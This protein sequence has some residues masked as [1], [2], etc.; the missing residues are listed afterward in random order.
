M[1]DLLDLQDLLVWKEHQDLKVLMEK[2]AYLV[3]LDSLEEMEQLD[4]LEYLVQWELLENP[5]Q[6][7]DHLDHLDH[8]VTWEDLE[9]EDLRV[10][11]ESREHLV[12]MVFLALL[13]LLVCLAQWDQTDLLDHLDIQDLM[14]YPAN[15]DL[16]DRWDQ[17]GR[18]GRGDLR[19]HPVTK[20][21]KGWLDQKV[22]S[23]LVGIVETLGTLD[24]RELEAQ[25]DLWEPREQLDFLV[26]KVPKALLVR[27]E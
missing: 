4:N 26:T 22:W 11:G 5:D 20:D 18:R 8:L 7:E 13:E 21:K 2:L 16:R 27:R 17:K 3:F 15:L 19:G 25:L 9:K 24:K 10:S 12:L 23:D 14:V 1:L 6:Y